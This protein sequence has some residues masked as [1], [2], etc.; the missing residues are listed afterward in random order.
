M[1]PRSRTETCTEIFLPLRLAVCLTVPTKR[2]MTDL[3]EVGRKLNIARNALE[4]R[5]ERWHE[6]NPAWQPTRIFSRDGELLTTKRG[7]PRVFNECLPRL[8]R[9]K[10]GAPFV[11]ADV[12]AKSV[13]ASKQAKER[14][15]KLAIEGDAGSMLLYHHFREVAPEIAAKIGSACVQKVMARLQ[16]PMPY[17]HDGKSQWRWQAIMMNEVARDTFRGLEIPVPMQDGCVCYDGHAT[18][19]LSP[20]IMQAIDQH[21]KSG[22]VVYFTLFGNSSGREKK[23][24]LCRLHVGNLSA[25]H[26]GLL[27]KIVLGMDGFKAADSNLVYHDRGKPD[28]GWYLHLTYHRPTE[29]HS[30]LPENVARLDAVIGDD[31]ALPNAKP[32]TI[33]R[34][35]TQ[36]MMKLDDDNGNPPKAP[37]WTLGDA[38]VLEYQHRAYEMRV[39]TLRHRSKDENQGRY[40]HGKRSFYAKVRPA[41]DAQRN[42]A[43]RFRDKLVS[44]IF[45]FCL[46][47][48]CGV[49]EYTEPRSTQGTWFGKR[50]ISFAWERFSASLK[51]KAKKYGVTLR[52]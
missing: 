25:G 52:S 15:D 6:D 3:N 21:G 23:G 49:L 30:L 27:R 1:G 7:D 32:F 5:F 9:D 38:K 39:K 51:Y 13:L 12:L 48:H 18:H 46:R 42:L 19:R 2:M 40:G 50:R 45:R 17:N 29:D 43:K 26:R 35:M 8:Y 37:R 22:C 16:L 28:D 14:G 11:P 47:F 36:M 33:E 4:R 31:A 24:V 41:G 44:E 20:G 10:P 34:M